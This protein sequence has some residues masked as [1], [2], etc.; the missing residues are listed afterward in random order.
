MHGETF[1][2]GE[3]VPKVFYGYDYGAVK[4]NSIHPTA[5]IE[6]VPFRRKLPI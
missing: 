1:V 5:I 3:K 4:M 2:E 6:D